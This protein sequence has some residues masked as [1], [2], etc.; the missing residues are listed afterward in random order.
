MVLNYQVPR[1]A[2]IS[3]LADMI[4]RNDRRPIRV[5]TALLLTVGQ[6]G[7]VIALCIFKLDAGQR[8]FFLIWSVLLAAL[9]VLRRATVRM[10]A[11]GTLQRL[12]Y[13]GQLPGDYWDKHRLKIRDGELRLQY[14]QQECSCALSAI[15]RIDE[16]HEA[17][18]I[19]C[20]EAVFDIVPLSA[21][22]GPEQMAAFARK[23]REMSREDLSAREEKAK[24]EA[25]TAELRWE[26][27]AREF[28]NAQYL[29]YRTLYYRY[30]FLR[31]A[32]FLRLAV[33]VFAVV[34]LVTN[35]NTV[36]IVLCAVLLLLANLENLSMI[37]LI[38]KKRISLETGNWGESGEYGL[39]LEEGGLRLLSRQEQVHIPFEK[40]IFC[41]EIRNY[42][43]IAW[44]N[45]PAVVIPGEKLGDQQ[46]AQLIQQVKHS[47]RKPA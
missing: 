37:P 14:G 23:L 21:F 17:L 19:Y 45:F 42:C 2:Y 10:R 12:E 11:K 46:A 29:A 33:S 24:G 36:N 4:R 32:T 6:L 3:L 1:E 16:V 41:E 40:I 39:T 43:V 25:L 22:D 27:G 18:Y 47:I 30:R 26:M 28:L 7:V 38:C 20:G 8:P 9:T 44:N 31:K 34:N 15:S 13:S 5:L 35:P